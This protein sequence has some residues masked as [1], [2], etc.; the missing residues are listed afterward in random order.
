MME[1]FWNS[2]D[3]EIHEECGVFGVYGVENAAS[4]TYYGLHSLQ[5]RGQEVAGIVSV[6][7]DKVLKRGKGE[8]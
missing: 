6:N 7:A 4:I 8:C 5:H 2:D 1:Q 3:R